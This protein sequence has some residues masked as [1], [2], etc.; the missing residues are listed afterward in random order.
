MVNKMR[1]FNE[2]CELLKNRYSVEPEFPWKKDLES[3]VFRHINSNKWFVLYMVVNNDKLG[4]ENNGV[5]NIINLKCYPEMIGTLRMKEC[6]L[7]AYHMNKE[8]WISVILDGK[9]KDSEI[10]S[11][12][13]ISYELTNK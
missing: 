6:I 11:L 12:I 9:L 2:L 3:A 10:L 5:S 8:H 7:P 4:I 1:N 13:D